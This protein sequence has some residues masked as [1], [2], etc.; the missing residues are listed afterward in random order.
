MKKHLNLSLNQE[1]AFWAK[2]NIDNLSLLVENIII[3]V[4]EQK[5]IKPDQN[6]IKLKKEI[7]QLKEQNLKITQQITFK[8]ARLEKLEQDEKAE[9]D[10]IMDK[11]IK[12]SQSI[13]NAGLLNDLG[14]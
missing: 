3:D 12:D 1:L 14:L 8:R 2:D 7:E 11:A 9:N 10:S 5:G 13:K 4:M 6:K